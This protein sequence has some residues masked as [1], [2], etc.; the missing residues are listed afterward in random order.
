MT[1]DSLLTLTSL[2]V[3]IWA[4]MPRARRLDLILK[5]RLTDWLFTSF[6]FIC[7]NYLLFYKTFVLLGWTPGWKLSRWGITPQNA[8]YLFLTAAFS[9]L[10]LSVKTAPLPRKKIL[11][12]KELCDELLGR[13]ENHAELISL[14]EKHL[15][16]LVRIYHNDYFLQNIKKKLLPE[17]KT[18]TEALASLHEVSVGDEKQKHKN[19]LVMKA[20]SKA[21]K[22]LLENT[23]PLRRFLNSRIPS[24][25]KE[26]A[27][28]QELFRSILSNKSFIQSVISIKPYFAI[29]VFELHIPEHEKEDFIDYYFRGLLA[30]RT[31]VLYA[32]LKNNQNQLVNHR[33][34]LPEANRLLFYLFFQI[35]KAHDLQVWRPIGEQALSD[36]DKLYIES[37]TDIYNLPHDDSGWEW[38]SSVYAAIHFFDIMIAEA[39]EQKIQWHMW[40]YYYTHFTNSICRN[41]DPNKRYASESNTKYSHLLYSMISTLCNWIRTIEEVPIDQSNVALDSTSLEH[42]NGNLIKSSMLAMGQCIKSILITDKI[43]PDFRKEMAALPISLYYDLNRRDEYANYAEVLFESLLSGGSQYGDDNGEKYLGILL[44]AFVEHDNIPHKYEHVNVAINHISSKYFRKY[45]LGNI[46]RFVNYSE[47][48]QKIILMASNGHRYK[49][50]R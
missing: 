23:L 25:G 38:E 37:D 48:G 42:E 19:T 16:V 17:A 40:L 10:I 36:L 6:V 50:E 34:A 1:V 9:L 31:S 15:P 5:L 28:A 47:E 41:F 24:Y 12:I 49:V 35:N 26:T 14:L 32:E 11:K 43:H 8:S 46:R 18:L 30:E 45:G 13:K 39:I 22:Y 7:L 20:V 44:N 2:L 29:E 27:I 33:Y 21:G 4:L 3:A